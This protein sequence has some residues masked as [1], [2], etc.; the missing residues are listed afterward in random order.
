MSAEEARYIKRAYDYLLNS[1]GVD[2]N[3][4][5]AIRYSRAY[6]EYT[7]RELLAGRQPLDK[8]EAGFR[9]AGAK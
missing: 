5:D 3:N 8:N 9:L 1:M 4:G 2:Y 6:V 7:F